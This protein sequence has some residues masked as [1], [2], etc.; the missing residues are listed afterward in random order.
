[1]PL[2]HSGHSFILQI[3]QQSN[4]FQGRLRALFHAFA[5]AI[6]FFS[7]NNDVVFA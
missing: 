7:V 1:M 5:A 6:A 2:R 3:N 4:H